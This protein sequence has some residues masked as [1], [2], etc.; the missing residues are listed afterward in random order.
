MKQSPPGETRRQVAPPAVQPVKRD[1]FVHLRPVNLIGDPGVDNGRQAARRRRRRAI[2]GEAARRRRRCAIAGE[3]AL[4]RIDEVFRPR[5]GCGRQQHGSGG[6]AAE[7][8]RR[9]LRLELVCAA[10]AGLRRGVPHA[11]A[12]AQRRAS[13]GDRAGRGAGRGAG[14]V[15]RRSGSLQGLQLTSRLTRSREAQP[16]RAGRGRRRR[17]RCGRG[18]SGGGKAYESAESAV[19][20]AQLLRDIRANLGPHARL[21]CGQ[22]SG[23]RRS[24]AHL[25]RHRGRRCR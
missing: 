13:R 4:R 9:G 19:S 22:P 2:A 15:A 21:N 11:A 24:P 10:G 3:P 23:C 20:L 16:R 17:R 25:Q 18:G 5:V 14:H 1:L 8:G 6:S 12:R 7:R